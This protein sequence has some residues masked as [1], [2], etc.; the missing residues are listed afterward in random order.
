MQASI[1]G[2][3]ARICALYSRDW[4]NKLA[5]MLQKASAEGYGS[6]RYNSLL[7]TSSVYSHTYQGIVRAETPQAQ[8][9]SVLYSAQYPELGFRPVLK[10]DDQ[11]MFQVTNP[12]GSISH[13]GT[14]YVD[15]KPIKP[16]NPFIYPSIPTGSSPIVHNI[17]FGDT[18]PGYELSWVWQNGSMVCTY[19]P[20]VNFS[21]EL[22]Y[23]LCPYDLH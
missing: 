16:S 15:G 19:T 23:A 11:E 13:G 8:K 17:Q 3:S 9:A 4:T 7:F 5:K 18:E 14:M 20:I 6:V 1:D 21:A 12:D 22:L 2:E 10:F